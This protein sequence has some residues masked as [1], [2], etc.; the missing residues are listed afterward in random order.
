MNLQ[1]HIPE[2]LWTAVSSAYESENYSHAILEATYYLSTLIRERAGV[3]GDG[4][5]LVGQALGGDLPRLKLTALQTESDKNVQKGF[6]QILRGVYVGIRNPRSHEQ[7]A[8]TKETADAI[9][10]FL[11]Y[12]ATLLNAS[13]EAFTIDAF[14]ERVFDPEFVESERYA[15]L[16]VEEVPKFR[17]GDAIT[18]LFRARRRAEL[19]KL[20]YLVRV[21]LAALAPNQL[22]SYLSVVS[23]ELRTTT[24]DAAIRTAL[25]MLTPEVWP[26]LSEL[27]RLRIENKLI[28]GLRAGETL[29]S[30]KSTEALATWSSPFLRAFTLRDQA[31]NA[32]TWKLEDKNLNARRY[33]AK[34]FMRQL[35][36]VLSTPAQTDRCI[37]AIAAAI[38]ADDEYV[39]QALII[40]IRSYP[41]EWQTKLAA[42]LKDK[43]DANNPAVNLADGT[44]FLSSPTKDESDDEIPF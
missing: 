9:I 34:F 13:K 29:Q 23:E 1:T 26:S 21:L 27:P 12:V 22:S 14:V 2:A 19:R 4:V 36:E 31:A 11:G 7:I 3:D 39:R 20:R 15:E 24:D 8:D 16:I 10:H 17:L 18:A 42:E 5:A 38:K 40:W 28:T 6:E 44:P 25:Q 30:G 43:T 37:R 32:L 41:V 35:P 33:A